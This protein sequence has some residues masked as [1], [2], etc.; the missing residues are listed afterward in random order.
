MLKDE[1]ANERGFFSFAERTG[2]RMPGS[3]MRVPG[4]DASS[5]RP[6]PALGEDN[7]AVLADWLGAD[8]DRAETLLREGIL[9]SEPPG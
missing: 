2:E 7:A 4:S 6:C 8:A 3:P 9:R 1:Q 5:W